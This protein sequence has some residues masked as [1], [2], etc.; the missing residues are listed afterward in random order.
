MRC[1]IPGST[2]RTEKPPRSRVWG[3]SRKRGLALM[4]CGGRRGDDT[5]PGSG[6]PLQTRLRF[7]LII[8]AHSSAVVGIEK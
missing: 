1:G 6:V 2:L 4:G 5:P 7:S 8:F 3:L